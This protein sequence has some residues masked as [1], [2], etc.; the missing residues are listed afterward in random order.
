MQ[1]LALKQIL[2]WWPPTL[3]MYLTFSSHGQE[4]NCIA[5]SMLLSGPTTKRT[6]CSALTA[7][8]RGAG[9]GT[10]GA[11]GLDCGACRSAKLRDIVTFHA[12]RSAIV[13]VVIPIVGVITIFPITEGGAP[14]SAMTRANMVVTANVASFSCARTPAECTPIIDS[15][16]AILSWAAAKM[17]THAE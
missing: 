11:T 4:K 6:I 12:S 14:Y 17:I 9:C 7:C 2:L 3:L 13:S 10:G 5:L 16:F 1:S 8:A 15:A